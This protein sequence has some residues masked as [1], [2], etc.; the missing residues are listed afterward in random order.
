MKIPKKDALMWFEFFAMLPEDQ[1]LMVKQQEIIYATFA[2]IEETIDHRNDILMSQIKGLKNLENRTFFVG[3]DNKFS[4]GCRSCLFGTGLGAIR[5]TNK[6]DAQCKFCYNYGELDNLPPIGEGMWEIGGTKFYEKDID[7]LLSIHKKPTGVAY[8][9]LEPFM[10]IEKYYSVIKKFKAAGI[11]QHLYTNGI[12]ATE[13]TL[14]ALGE[15]GL[16]EI[17]FNL[18]ATNC[19]DKVIENI[20]I[21]K[22]YIQNVGIETPMTPEFFEEFSKKKQAILDTKLDFINC[23]ELHLND[24][25][26]YNYSEENMYISRQGYISPIW[27]RELTLKFMKIAD[28]ENWDLAVHDCSNHTKFARDLNLSS[29]EE[30]WFGASNY[31]CEFSRIPYEAFLPILSDD[32]FKFLSEEELPS[33]YKPGELIF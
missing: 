10:E 7:L 1:E 12:S 16:D 3:N 15:A 27:S 6:C 20:K 24:N 30:R 4:K 29:K 14:K 2:Q 23:A 21:A 32:N 8:V 25:N 5:K 28:E 26:I 13:E 22:K 17:R 33:G 31:A 9:Y 19:S 18:G 11:Y